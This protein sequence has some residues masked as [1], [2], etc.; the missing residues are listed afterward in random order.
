MQEG[1][2][3]TLRQ[4]CH[5]IGVFVRTKKNITGIAGRPMQGQARTIPA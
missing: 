2:G 1:L 3:R 4:G 5:L